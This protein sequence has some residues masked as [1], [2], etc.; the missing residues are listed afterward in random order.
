MKSTNSRN[1]NE[2]KGYVWVRDKS[3]G[4]RKKAKP[5]FGADF[6]RIE[7]EPITQLDHEIQEAISVPPEV[8]GKLI[9]EEERTLISEALLHV[10]IPEKAKACIRLMLEG[11]NFSEIGRKLGIADTSA[12]WH[13]KRTIPKIRAWIHEHS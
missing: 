4:G 6:G 2:V 9:Q 10:D 8:L 3:A 1:P 12:G 5:V 13:V 7:D 11:C